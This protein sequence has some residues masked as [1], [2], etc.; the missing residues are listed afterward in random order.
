MGRTHLV[1]IIFLFIAVSVL[2]WYG[3]QD[4]NN[5]FS[6]EFRCI[7]A[8]ND[9]TAMFVLNQAPPRKKETATVV[10][11]FDTALPLR[12]PLPDRWMLISRTPDAGPV[13]CFSAPPEKWVAFDSGRSA[14]PPV[15][16]PLPSIESRYRENGIGIEKVFPFGDQRSTIQITANERRILV[17]NS[18]TF[19]CSDSDRTPL[20][21]KIDILVITHAGHTDSVLHIRSLFR[22][23]HTII[24]GPLPETP[25]V[26]DNVHI[27]GRRYP[28]YFLF[29]S[30]PK[31]RFTLKKRYSGEP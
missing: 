26:A 8:G 25:P 30:T 13:S 11:P 17:I 21:E 24:F 23:L 15:T 22:P 5:P 3:M 18:A 20:S 1:K 6:P 2:T 12:F 28:E 16:W 9:A 27:C 10:L 29:T 4:R 19:S 31:K 14:T 7:V